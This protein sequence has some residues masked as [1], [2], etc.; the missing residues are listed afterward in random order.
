[1]THPDGIERDRIQTEGS[2]LDKP[3]C[4]IATD[5]YAK[6]RTH[7]SEEKHGDH[8]EVY[9]DSYPGHCREG[10]EPSPVDD[11]VVVEWELDEE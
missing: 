7:P 8:A 3:S 4:W 2:G 11:S 1:M 5:L 10:H 6:G 9:D